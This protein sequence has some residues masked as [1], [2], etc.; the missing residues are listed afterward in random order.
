VHAASGSSGLLPSL[1]RLLRCLAPRPRRRPSKQACLPGA[2]VR[3]LAQ[4]PA[5]GLGRGAVGGCCWPGPSAS[6]CGGGGKRLPVRG[7]AAA[8]EASSGGA[9]RAAAGGRCAAAGRAAACG[10]RAAA[11]LGGLQRQRWQWR[12][13]SR[14]ARGRGGRRCC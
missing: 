14:A 2:A 1:P 4:A 7:A 8:G 11:L 5:V 3:G 6:A 13:R 9:G 12:R 10:L